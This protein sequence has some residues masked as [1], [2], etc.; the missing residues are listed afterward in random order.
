M[1]TFGGRRNN[2]KT[3]FILLLGGMSMNRPTRYHTAQG[4]AILEY[5]ASI[6]GEHVTAAQVAEHF[7]KARPPIGLTTVY[8]HLERL[9]G[10]G[11]VRK[12]FVDSLSSACYQYVAEG[13]NCHEHFHLKCETCGTLLHLECGTLDKIQRHVYEEHSFF[14]DKCRMVFYG[15]CA[16]CMKGLGV[17]AENAGA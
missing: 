1:L 4:K 15:K 6:G 3:V 16:D 9:A 11:R 14:I 12:Y 17:T 10:S 2:M 13:E 8:R 7:G 5:L